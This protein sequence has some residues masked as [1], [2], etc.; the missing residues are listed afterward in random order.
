MN[1]S[2][3]FLFWTG[4]STQQQPAL[5]GTALIGVSSQQSSQPGIAAQ[6]PLQEHDTSTGTYGSPSLYKGCSG[7]PNV[8]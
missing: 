2:I 4:S 1:I 7:Y 8:L 5:G 3:Y 6:H